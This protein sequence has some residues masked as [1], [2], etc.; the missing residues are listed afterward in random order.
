MLCSC[1]KCMASFTPCRSRRTWTLEEQA[2]FKQLYKQ[3]RKDFKLYVPHFDGRTLVQIKSFYQNVVHKNKQIQ[4]SRIE[5]KTVNKQFVSSI[6][7]VQC[8]N[9]KVGFNDMSESLF[10]LSTVPFDNLDLQQ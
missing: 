2:L 4:S 5:S 8:Q 7:S 10:E 6:D 1:V 3:Y 9:E